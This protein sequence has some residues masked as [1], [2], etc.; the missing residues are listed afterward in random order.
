ML[1]PL[2]TLEAITTGRR[3]RYFVIRVIYALSLLFVLWVAY[4]GNT[5][6]NQTFNVQRVANV[7]RDFFYQFTWMQLTAVLLLTPAMTA[8][9]VAGELER[10]TLDYLL[11]TPLSSFAI[12]SGKLGA[13]LL[14]AAL[15]VTTGVPVMALAMILG[16]IPPS[17]LLRTTIVS[18]A[19][20]LL[21]GCLSLAVSVWAVRT[22]D[23]VM[24]TYVILLALL[25][26]PVMIFT[27]VQSG[28]ASMWLLS[29]LSTV[30]GP[31]FAINPYVV[32]YTSDATHFNISIAIYLATSAAILAWASWR[33]RHVA[34]WRAGGAK[35]IWLR[36]PASLRWK[37][38]KRPIGNDAMFWKEAYIEKAGINGCVARLAILALSGWLILMTCAFVW[39][40]L[41]HGRND[42]ETVLFPYGF[43]TSITLIMCCARA[44]TL[45]TSE[46]ERDTWTVLIS[47][48][49][50]AREF[51]KGKLLGNL[52]AMRWPFLFGTGLLAIGSV[53]EFSFVMRAAVMLGILT[54]LMAFSTLVGLHGS[55]TCRTSLKAMGSG[56]GI[57]VFVG[58][59]YLCCCFPAMALFMFD[60][61][62][63][64]GEVF[65]AI[66]MAPCIPYL[67][68]APGIPWPTHSYNSEFL[69]FAVAAVL[70][71]LS[72]M[73]AT[74]MLYLGM[75]SE[76]DKRAGRMGRQAN[77]PERDLPPPT[78]DSP[79][80][81]S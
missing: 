81:P 18:L 75:V 4:E 50:T 30:S 48:P 44:A 43:L 54:L 59:G 51:I 31:A 39:A 28:S 70:G 3:Y 47:T 79:A 2:F 52:Y 17:A 16:G 6:W 61:G 19:T 72:Y 14:L 25:S 60:S 66:L 40:S 12:L 69:T 80:L 64:G 78:V 41:S 36:R 10:K 26:V 42:P 37:R 7:A 46:K 38:W 58:G 13:R 53:I 45:I 55:M 74:Y 33:L 63:R 5:R 62:P 49:L 23:A 21:T 34:A 65:M 11:A 56:V 73:A 24:R 71:S 29:F 8:G 77:Q 27:T 57:L 76:F 1:S 9:T 68:I 15:L 67:L 20:L 32:A 22:R 35:R